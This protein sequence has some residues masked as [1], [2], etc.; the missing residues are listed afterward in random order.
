MAGDQK[1]NLYDTNDELV[2][3][4]P[5]PWHWKNNLATRLERIIYLTESKLYTLALP[6]AEPQLFDENNFEDAVWLP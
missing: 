4:T 2:K 1:L 6:I 5:N 3:N